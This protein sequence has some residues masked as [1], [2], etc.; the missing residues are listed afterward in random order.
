MSR[1]YP[2][3]VHDF[4]REY[5]PGHT[6]KETVKALKKKTGIDMG[7]IALASYKKNHHIKSGTSGGKKSGQPTKLYPKK[8]QDYIAA[9]AHGTSPAQMAED[10]YKQFR[11]RYKESQIRAYYKNHKI[12]SGL[13]TRFQ[14]GC[15]PW[16]KGRKMPPNE[17]S[18]RTQFKAG[19]DPW[20]KLPI[21]TVLEKADGYL[22]RKIGDGAREWKQEHIARWEEE[23][24]PLK[25]G[26]LIIFLDGDKHN[27]SMDNLRKI[28]RSINLEMNR[29]GM[30]FDDAALTE[31]GALI[32]T[33]RV[34]TRKR[35]R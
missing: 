22:W 14:P 15:I 29:T 25:D 10:L 6:V 1:R 20:N 17:N 33:L 18:Q 35:K 2:Q 12:S 34:E 11:R 5:I 31:S 8:V 23:H 3:E 19:E 7:E 28:D 9:H 30:R 16:T 26:E 32:A 27:L 24:G 21:G 13:D 4:L